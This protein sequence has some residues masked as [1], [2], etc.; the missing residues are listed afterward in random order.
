MGTEDACEVDGGL[1]RAGDYKVEG[2]ENP[3]VVWRRDVHYVDVH[4]GSRV[5]TGPAVGY[6]DLNCREE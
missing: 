4:G 2:E 3:W 6:C 1:D 5:E